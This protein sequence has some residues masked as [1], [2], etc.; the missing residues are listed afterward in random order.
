[1]PSVARVLPRER[2]RRTSTGALPA[3]GQPPRST[4]ARALSRKA[5]V[6]ISHVL[7]RCSLPRSP[8]SE[9]P[10]A[11]LLTIA[12]RTSLAC[13]P[14]CGARSPW[15]R[16]VATRRRARWPVG[17]SHPS[18]GPSRP[19]DRNGDQAGASAG[20]PG[21]CYRA[22]IRAPQNVTWSLATSGPPKVRHV[23]ALPYRCP[24]GRTSGFGRKRPSGRECPNGDKPGTTPADCSRQL[25]RGKAAVSPGPR[26]AA[27]LLTSA[28]TIT[29]TGDCRNA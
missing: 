17:G 14:T 20:G 28:S 15:R 16:S 22:Q 8:M 25:E 23:A 24:A 6:R 13:R 1:V 4:A 21:A 19:R 7:D 2:K 9:R 18:P 3:T 27:R 5:L 29:A 11:R 26:L 12:H 10:P